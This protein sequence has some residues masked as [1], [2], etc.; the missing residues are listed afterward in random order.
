MRG[1]RKKKLRGLRS[2]WGLGRE[3]WFAT[4]VGWWEQSFNSWLIQCNVVYGFSLTVLTFGAFERVKMETRN[5][6]RPLNID[7]S[8]CT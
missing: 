6:V 1:G 2:D 8:F 4:C 7:F 5:L 3:W